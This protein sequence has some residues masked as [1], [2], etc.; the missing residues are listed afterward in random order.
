[1]SDGETTRNTPT[2]LHA[3]S[4]CICLGHISVRGPVGIFSAVTVVIQPHAGRP[5]TRTAL[6]AP[7]QSVGERKHAGEG[8]MNS[9]MSA[10]SFSVSE[11]RNQ[12]TGT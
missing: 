11:G 10:P 9:P 1:M 8:I 5:D 2:S 4:L 6:T 3:A 7:N 12:S